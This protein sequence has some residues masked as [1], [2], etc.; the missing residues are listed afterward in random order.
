MDAGRLGVP[1]DVLPTRFEGADSMPAEL[2]ARGVGFLRISSRTRGWP[3]E[4]HRTLRC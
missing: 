2:R 1:T 4:R 3:R